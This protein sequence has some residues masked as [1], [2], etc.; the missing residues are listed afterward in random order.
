MPSVAFLLTK[1]DETNAQVV[2][3]TGE[4]GT[5]T[6]TIRLGGCTHSGS[7][8]T[9]F[10]PYCFRIVPGFPSGLLLLF[11]LL[12]SIASSPVRASVPLVPDGTQEIVPVTVNHDDAPKQR[13][14]TEIGLPL[15]LQQYLEQLYYDG[16]DSLDGEPLYTVAYLFDLYRRNQ[17]QPLWTDPDSIGQLLNAIEDSAEEGLVPDD[18][19][20]TALLNLGRTPNESPAKEAQYELL[21]SDA[22][23]LLAQHKRHGKVDSLQVDEKQNLEMPASPLSQLDTYL[24][25]IRDGRIRDTLDRL[26]PNHQTY[27]KLKKGLARYQRILANGGWPQIPAGPSI[28]PGAS[29][30]RITTIRQ[31]L[32]ITD[33]Y[34]P[35][36][37]ASN[38]YDRKLV[39]AVKVFQQRHHL[40]PDGVIG[41][42][43]LSAMNVS[44]AERVG[45][46]RVNMERARWLIHDMPSSG[47]LIDIAGFMLEYYHNN[48]QVWT[49]RVVVGKPFHQTPVFR[50]AITYIVLNPTWT[51]P[52]KIVKNETV[53]KIAADPGYLARERLKVID[54]NGMEIDPNTIPWNQYL[55]KYLPYML[56]QSPGKDN[57]LG[58]IKFLF[59]NRYHVYLHDTPSK[60]LFGR[61]KRAFSHGCIR[62]QNPLE[63]GRLLLANDPGNPTTPKKMDQVIASGETTT[64]ILKQPLPVY[65]LYL[66]T[67]VKNNQLMFKNDLYDRDQAVLRALDARPRPL[68]AA[69]SADQQKPGLQTEPETTTDISV[70]QSRQDYQPIPPVTGDEP[71]PL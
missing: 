64:V 62:V 20:R 49:T 68:V 29:D 8:R 1:D 42:G 61:S 34:H 71:N 35:P 51:I 10:M 53:P 26:S 16:Q 65:L 55:G 9:V 32:A 46:I 12:L 57:A 39:Q 45:Q 56:R 21:L 54:S 18:Y 40:D 30:R 47:L 37:G 14:A 67:K 38:F 6:F 59:P 60:G 48:E 43:T 4:A 3:G 23:V 2:P 31:R 50:S 36:A 22:F 27:A 11:V 44:A 19:H 25:A 66:T 58:Q 28:A 17:F 69:L 7:F 63:M 33:G 5:R 70:V 24:R 41:K 13:Q 52:P 15:L